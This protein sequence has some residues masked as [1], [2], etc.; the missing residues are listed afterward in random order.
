MDE[1]DILSLLNFTEDILQITHRHKDIIIDLGWYPD[2]DPKGNFRLVLIKDKDWQN[3]IETF[4]TRGVEE[5]RNKIDD[6]LSTA[7]YRFGCIC[8]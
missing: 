5:V 6:F 2:M 1:N 8:K 4:E 7:Y 3:P